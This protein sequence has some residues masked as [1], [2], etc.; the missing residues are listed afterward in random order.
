MERTIIHEAVGH[1]GLEGVLGKDFDATCAKAAALMDSE[2]QGWLAT[3]S[4]PSSP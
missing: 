2:S 4:T 3:P 1:L